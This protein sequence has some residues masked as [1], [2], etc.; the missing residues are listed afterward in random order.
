MK[1]GEFTTNAF[2]NTKLIG[3][4][5]LCRGC[6]VQHCSNMREE[7]TISITSQLNLTLDRLI[8]FIADLCHR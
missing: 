6:I 2:L 3:G 1:K 4:T 7:R 8:Y 5:F